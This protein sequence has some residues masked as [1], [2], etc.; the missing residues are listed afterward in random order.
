[1]SDKEL[2]TL[3]QVVKTLRGDDDPPGTVVPLHVRT[4]RHA[5]LRVFLATPGVAEA[6]A[7]SD[8]ERGQ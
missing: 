7:A 4:A 1:M 6:L 2:A 3:V 8:A 5:A